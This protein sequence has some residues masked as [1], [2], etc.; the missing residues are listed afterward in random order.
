MFASSGLVSASRVLPDKAGAYVV[1]ARVYQRDV[2]VTNGI[3]RPSRGGRVERPGRSPGR[4]RVRGMER[5]RTPPA[6]ELVEGSST[7]ALVM[8][9]FGAVWGAA[10]AQALGGVVGAITLATSCALAAVLF[11][12]V[13]RPGGEALGLPTDGS[14]R[15][16]G[17]GEARGGE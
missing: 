5:E 17:S 6:R 1:A 11:L 8:T 10:G 7:G 15:A 4:D 9:I 14:P 13:R 2:G 16:R 12:G 3:A